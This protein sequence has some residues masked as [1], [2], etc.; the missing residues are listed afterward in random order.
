M[1]SSA[2]FNATKMNASA[3][4]TQIL[5][6]AVFSEMLAARMG[7]SIEY[8]VDALTFSAM[9]EQHGIGAS[10]IPVVYDLR[11]GLESAV[12]PMLLAPIETLFSERMKGS[13]VHIKSNDYLSGELA[14]TLVSRAAAGGNVW[15]AST[16]REDA[17]VHAL[18][19]AEEASEH[20]F[21]E[22]VTVKPDASSLE[23]Q[24]MLIRVTIPAGSELR[25]DSERYTVT[26]DGENILHLQE[27][28]WLALD[29][30]LVSIGL[31]S[32]VKGQLE[33]QV[34]VTERY[35]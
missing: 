21:S 2:R 1:F 35:L 10:A 9:L 11:A 32:G 12:S 26:L 3:V 29:R 5:L 20:V 16:L 13:F 8:R 15:F 4:R 14:D 19:G 23:E 22:I 31:D 7:I 17:D 24:V 27:G 6:Q 33:G 28:D 30:D 18:I 34:V 25:I